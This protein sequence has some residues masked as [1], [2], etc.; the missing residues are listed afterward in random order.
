MLLWFAGLSFVLVWTIFRDTALDYRLV[1]AGAL[2]PDVVDV[3]TG[4]AGPLHSLTVSV[5]LLF[6]VMAFTRR[7]RLL[8]RRLLAVPIGTF[9]HLLLDGMWRRTEV[10]WWPF[11]GWGF[12][13]TPLPTAAR[14]WPTIALMEVAGA[15][16]LVWAYRRFRLF[17]D[18]RRA[19]FLRTGRLGRDLLKPPPGVDGEPASC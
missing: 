15:I 16:A 14:A 17:E 18:E 7:R 5:A 13:D 12:A 11:F 9:V 2:L 10:F 3:V 1:M 8:R 19:K 4:G 6:A